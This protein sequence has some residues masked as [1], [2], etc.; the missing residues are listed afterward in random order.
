M[1][2]RVGSEQDFEKLV[3]DLIYLERDTIAAY[4][5]TLDR[6]SDPSP[7]D[8]VRHFRDDHRQHLGVL[9][10]MPTRRERRPPSKAT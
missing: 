8:E 1:V 4:E 3:T 6:L 5:T 7:K 2:T 10:Q 9:I